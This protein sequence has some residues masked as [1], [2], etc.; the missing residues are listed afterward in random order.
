MD[1]FTRINEPRAE[2]LMKMLEVIDTSAKSNRVTP[3]DVRELLLPVADKLDEMRWGDG[4]RQRVTNDTP[5]PKAPSELPS[6][7]DTIVP[8]NWRSVC[9][10]M[11]PVALS[12][13]IGYAAHRLDEELHK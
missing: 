8:D 7:F 9:D 12:A 13:L 1:N 2:K 3:Q 11:A 6:D 4:P 10:A 5:P